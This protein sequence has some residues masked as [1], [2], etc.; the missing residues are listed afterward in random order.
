MESMIETKQLSCKM[1][2][3]YLIKNIDWKV[4]QGEQWIVYGMNGCGKTTLLS[5]IAGYRHFTSGNIRIMGE[6]YNKDNILDLRK[7]IGFVSSSFFDKHYSR[8]NV[9]DIVLSG[10]T[11]CLGLGENL[12]LDDVVMAKELLNGLN[13]EGK[14]EKQFDMLSKGERQNVLLARALMNH[15]QL[16]ILDEPMSGLDIY[17][18]EYLFSVLESIKDKVTMVYVTHQAEEISG[19][20]N[21]CLLLKNGRVFSQG[22]M[23]DIFTSE[24]IS[25]FLD[26]PVSVETNIKGRKQ[27]SLDIKEAKLIELFRRRWK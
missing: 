20:F 12:S 11:G 21:R 6:E 25:E 5:I 4:E 13:L 23:E 15:P 26:Y 17:N 9:L 16:L 19:I 8:E 3:N 22:K 10:K 1:G 2:K 18:R 24:H 14:R 7:R 27:I